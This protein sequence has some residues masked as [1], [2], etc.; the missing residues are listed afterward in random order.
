LY[1]LYDGVC[2]THI[3]GA[4]LF[5]WC[6][7]RRLLCVLYK[8]PCVFETAFFPRVERQIDLDCSSQPHYT[9][10]ITNYLVCTS[11]SRRERVSGANVISQLTT[12]LLALLTPP[13]HPERRCAHTLDQSAALFAD[14][15][16]KYRGGGAP[17]K[18][19][20]GEQLWENFLTMRPGSACALS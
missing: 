18:R 2:T 11:R 16:E 13:L 6:S 1:K 7:E 17:R 5:N 9:R 15:Y 12:I 19:E 4:K 14:D 8:L 3:Q 20:K 10:G